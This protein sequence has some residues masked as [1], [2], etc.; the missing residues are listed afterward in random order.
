MDPHIIFNNQG[1]VTVRGT[2]FSFTKFYKNIAKPI[3]D[4]SGLSLCS[5]DPLVVESYAQ[6]AHQ[7]NL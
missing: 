1:K 2:I 4:Q 6:N 5:H 7:G 3:I